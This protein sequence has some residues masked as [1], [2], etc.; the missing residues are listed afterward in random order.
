[1]INS[2][3]TKSWDSAREKRRRIAMAT[4]KGLRVYLNGESFIFR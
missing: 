2:P 3:G 1:M 4:M